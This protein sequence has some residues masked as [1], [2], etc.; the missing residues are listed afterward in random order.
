MPDRPI[1]DL[2]RSVVMHELASALAEVAAGPE[3]HDP[4]VEWASTVQYIAIGSDS[5]KGPTGTCYCPLA[6]VQQ[7]DEDM[8]AGDIRRGFYYAWEER[9]D[10]IV[11][12]RELYRRENY[13]FLNE[14]EDYTSPVFYIIRVTD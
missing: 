10:N 4:I 3:L 12:A 11:K 8:P 9:I 2:P 7:W 1:I 13:T 14:A 5:E 6:G